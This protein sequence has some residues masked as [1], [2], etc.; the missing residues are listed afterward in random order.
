M[1]FQHTPLN[2]SFFSSTGSLTVNLLANKAQPELLHAALLAGQL[3]PSDAMKTNDQGVPALFSWA[4]SM[5]GDFSHS[6]KARLWQ[7]VPWP[8]APDADWSKANLLHPEPHLAN[9]KALKAERMAGWFLANLPQGMAQL[10]WTPESHQVVNGQRIA[11]PDHSMSLVGMAVGL[12]WERAL[13]Q[14]LRRPDAPTPAE[15]SVLLAS[16]TQ[17]ASF[18]NAFGHREHC[19]LPLL[20]FAVESDRLLVVERLLKAGADPNALDGSGT[21]VFFRAKSEEVLKALINAGARLNQKPTHSVNLAE[22]WKGDLAAPVA[23]SLLEITNAWLK[24]HLDEAEILAEKLPEL[25]SS[26]GRIPLSSFKQQLSQLKIPSDIRWKEFGEEWTLFRRSLALVLQSAPDPSDKKTAWNWGL[27]TKALGSP[28]LEGVPNPDLL[29]LVCQGY[30]P[31]QP[32]WDKGVSKGRWTSPKDEVPRLSALAQGL[33]Q[34]P[35]RVLDTDGPKMDTYGLWSLK[36]GRILLQEG[37]ED[38]FVLEVWGGVNES[39]ARAVHH[40]PLRCL[41]AALKRAWAHHAEGNPDG[42]GRWLGEALVWAGRVPPDTVV[43]QVMRW[44]DTLVQTQGW[45]ASA[46][47]AGVAALFN[48]AVH[49]HHA[50]EQALI[51]GVRLDDGAEGQRLEKT[52]KAWERHEAARPVELL[53]K[54]TWLQGRLASAGPAVRKPR[55]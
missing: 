40:E 25:V 5:A 19:W 13:D 2:Q 39:F 26:F 28:L 27:E 50:L 35:A 42:F 47:P 49:L 6:S 11:L 48:K 4:L 31:L 24:E 44:S 29:W 33:A 45:G 23:Q 21:P 16:H 36:L 22:W 53:A 17:Y 32:L 43:P 30:A 34:G 41:D 14:L 20:H 10:R 12:G 9:N 38:R 3:N 52:W 18:P 15:L 8:I 51:L 46:P 37:H 1:D 7:D 55:M 54:D